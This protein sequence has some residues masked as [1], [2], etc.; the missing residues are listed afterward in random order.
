MYND[1]YCYVIYA[2]EKTYKQG[3]YKTIE[4]FQNG[5]LGNQ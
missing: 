4:Q 3:N 2:D 1:V 5:E